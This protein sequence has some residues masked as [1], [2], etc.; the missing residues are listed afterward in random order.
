MFQ[1]IE[2]D[3]SRDPSHS[4]E[5]TRKPD[6]QFLAGPSNTKGKVVAPG[7]VDESY[8]DL[9]VANER[10][11]KRLLELEKDNDSMTK[12][13]ILNSSQGTSNLRVE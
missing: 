11:R 12:A 10:M 8:L 7:V 1:G 3:R 5:R 13:L 2:G 9:Q 4:L 6:T